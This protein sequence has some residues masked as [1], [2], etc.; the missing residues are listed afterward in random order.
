MQSQSKSEDPSTRTWTWP[1]ILT[2]AKHTP[3]TSTTTPNSKPDLPSPEQQ[4]LIDS[5]RTSPLTNPHPEQDQDQS[6]LKSTIEDILSEYEDENDFS[7]STSTSTPNDKEEWEWQNLHAFLAFI[8]K[9]RI[10]PLEDVGIHVLRVALER[11]VEHHYHH[12][13]HHHQLGTGV[14]PGTGRSKKMAVFVSCAAIWALVMGEEL[15]ERRGGTSQEEFPVGLSL[16]PRE[17]VA[18]QD[19]V[20]G[21]AAVSKSR[22]QMWIDRFQFLSLAEDLD[23]KSR[24]LAAE[25]AAVMRRVT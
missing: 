20:H 22:W 18:P 17:S 4:A 6:E 12:G 7:T 21:E 25:A 23:I 24:E 3:R 5:L 19:Q 8:T 15:W 9:E 2:T 11:G 14:P 10:V 13:H 16:S 1:S